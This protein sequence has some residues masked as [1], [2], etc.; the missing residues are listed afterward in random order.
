MSY[1]LFL[2]TAA[3]LRYERAAKAAGEQESVLEAAQKMQ[4]GDISMERLLRLFGCGLT[5]Q[6]ETEDELAE[7]MD[8]VGFTPAMEMLGKALADSVGGL[9]EEAPAKN[10]GRVS[11]RRR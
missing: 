11:K 6:L 9:N 1:R 7:L 8:T 10:S 4:A 3:M 5:P 2:G